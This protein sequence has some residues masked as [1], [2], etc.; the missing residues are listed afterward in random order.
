MTNSNTEQ[1]IVEHKHY[2]MGR[3]T[4]TLVGLW[5]APSQ[6]ILESNPLAYNNMMAARPTHCRMTCDHCGTGIIH[7]FIIKDEDGKLFSVGSSCIDKL[8]QH[9]LTTAAKQMEKK[10]QSKL[11]AERREAERQ[12]KAE[13][14]AKAE[15]EQR[16][17][18]GGLTD[19]EVGIQRRNEVIAEFEAQCREVAQP[20]IAL[21]KKAG[22]DFCKSLATSLKQGNLPYGRGR[23]LLLEITSKQYSGSRVGSKAYKAAYPQM[24][25]TL[26]RVESK[27]TELKEAHIEYLK[28]NQF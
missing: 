2:E 7:H 20:I 5:S 10:R 23:S 13:E 24:V 22:G 12:R 21:L 16:Q 11:R 28:K 4:Y 15:A 3:G 26:E 18:N 6:S 25:E 1:K 27:I 9:R 14:F 17:N 19:R 8:G